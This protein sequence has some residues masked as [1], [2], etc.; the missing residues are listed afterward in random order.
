M[1]EERWVYKSMRIYPYTSVILE[2]TEILVRLPI[3]DTLKIP[4]YPYV[5][6]LTN[7]ELAIQMD[8]LFKKMSVMISKLQPPRCIES[9]KKNIKDN[10]ERGN[11]YN[12]EP[13]QTL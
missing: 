7:P 6:N 5:S 4:H 9:L 10:I 13:Y 1:T 3:D 2:P 8:K 11:R 12:T